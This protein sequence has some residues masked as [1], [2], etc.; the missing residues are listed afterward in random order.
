MN[1]FKN[2]FLGLEEPRHPRV[3]DAQKC[4]RV[5][6]HLNDLEEVGYGVQS[7]EFGV[8]CYPNPMKEFAT[9]EFSNPGNE[10]YR[11][12][13]TDMTGKVVRMVEEIRGVQ[14][15]LERS[16]LESGVYIIKLEGNKV[17]R[18]VLIAE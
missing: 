12:T 16:G 7:S 3:A 13:L 18:G 4:M 9:I 6:G 2:Y 5:S 1:Q 14:Y 17:Y 15:E 10:E 8:R 11:L